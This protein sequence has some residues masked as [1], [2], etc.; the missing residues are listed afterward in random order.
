V[1]AKR[2]LLRTF[3][4]RMEVTRPYSSWRA[5]M[6]AMHGMY[7]ALMPW[8]SAL[9]ALEQ[10]IRRQNVGELRL[11]RGVLLGGECRDPSAV[12]CE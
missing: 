2:D 10:K 4:P 3:H 5:Q 1:W 12:S 9:D 7:F 6:I 11:V 8:T